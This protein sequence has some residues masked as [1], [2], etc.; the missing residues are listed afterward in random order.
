MVRARAGEGGGVP[1]DYCDPEAKTPRLPM[2]YRMIDNVLR[3]L[4]EEALE[5]ARDDPPKE[6]PP[7]PL[8]PSFALEIPDIVSVQPTPDGLMVFIG[9]RDGKLHCVNSLRGEVVGEPID[10][11]DSI[12]CMAM[13]ANGRLLAVAVGGAGD[14]EDAEPKPSTV[15]L[16]LVQSDKPFLKTVHSTPLS[17][18][19]VA[20]HF[21]FDSC[22]FAALLKSGQLECFRSKITVPLEHGIPEESEQAMVRELSSV[23][24][25]ADGGEAPH[26][27]KAPDQLITEPVRVLLTHA[28][29]AP[30]PPGDLGRGTVVLLNRSPR[31]REVGQLEE[32]H[33]AHVNMV[34]LG[35]HAVARYRLRED[36]LPPPPEGE[37]PP[38]PE[39]GPEKQLRLP[40][41]ASAVAMDASSALLFTGM[42]NGGCVLWNN[43]FG[44]ELFALRRHKAA[45]T[46]AAFTLYE[47]DFQAPL[48]VTAGADA[49]IHV[50]DSKDGSLTAAF[51]KADEL[52]RVLRILPTLVP[53]VLLQVSDGAEAE[54]AGGNGCGA[55]QVFSLES[56]TT[57][58]VLTL[59][60][61]YMQEARR[62]RVEVPTVARELGEMTGLILQELPPPKP[63][64]P[65]GEEAEEEEVPEGEE[66]P[67]KGKCKMIAYRLIDM[68]ALVFPELVKKQYGSWP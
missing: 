45:V 61:P 23:Q 34:T 65:E 18:E 5:V 22:V 24:T 19:A 44:T 10:L 41:A 9:T 48:L 53:L 50:H 38:P 26:E 14:E 42:S 3:D 49:V 62:T 59:P 56:F 51:Q 52:P 30:P 54:G 20:I 35:S 16:M 63:P 12:R 67:K 46:A 6:E 64:P 43:V 7:L 39:T 1:G 21:S 2:P 25:P 68:L 27:D 33:C 58:A 32:Q 47:A 60:P 36:A 57:K 31:V 11:E 4:I 13:T 66:D 28:P 29:A 37:D 15:K 17:A 40:H 55:L 8:A